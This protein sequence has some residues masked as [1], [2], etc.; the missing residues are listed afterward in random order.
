MYLLDFEVKAF[1]KAIMY[2]WLFFVFGFGF[3]WHF[4]KVAYSARKLL[5]FIILMYGYKF[6][7]RN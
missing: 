2:G 5:A 4:C 1:P 3:F 6:D 7:L